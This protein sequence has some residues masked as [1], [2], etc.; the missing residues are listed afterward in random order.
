MRSHFCNG[1]FDF[2]KQQQ[3]LFLILS[4]Y[5]QLLHCQLYLE[6]TSLLGHSSITRPGHLKTLAIIVF[7]VTYKTAYR[8]QEMNQRT[9]MGV[10]GRECEESGEE[11]GLKGERIRGGK[12]V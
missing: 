5:L 10:K 12:G 8:K 6:E 2:E 4:Q 1:N 11:V 3:I 7:N 9:G